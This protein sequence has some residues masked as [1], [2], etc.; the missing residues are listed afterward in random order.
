MVHS[1]LRPS[2]TAEGPWEEGEGGSTHGEGA[3]GQ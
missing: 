3:R 1:K 2:V